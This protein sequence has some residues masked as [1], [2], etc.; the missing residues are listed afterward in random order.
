MIFL[1][2]GLDVAVFDNQDNTVRM[3]MLE[4]NAIRRT[5]LELISPVWEKRPKSVLGDGYVDYIVPF[6]KRAKD[7]YRDP[8]CKVFVDLYM[9]GMKD[10]SKLNLQY[11]SENLPHNTK[12]RNLI[13]TYN[14]RL[15]Y[16]VKRSSVR[17]DAHHL[18]FMDYNGVMMPWDMWVDDSFK[19]SMEYFDPESISSVLLYENI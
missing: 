10:V 3:V 8:V 13:E 7:H 19:N 17:L 16:A 9:D 11:V 4:R 15:H 12:A 2:S 1:A 18:N 5:W 14:D 6:M